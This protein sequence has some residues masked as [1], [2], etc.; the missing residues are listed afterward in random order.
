MQKLRC[1]TFSSECIR[2][3]IGNV[4]HVERCV[5]WIHVARQAKALNKLAELQ[6]EVWG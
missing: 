2:T 4:H 6:P 5:K 1:C 3:S